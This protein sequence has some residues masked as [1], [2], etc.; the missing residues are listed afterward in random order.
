VTEETLLIGM[1][2]RPEQAVERAVQAL[3][4]AERASRELDD[5]GEAAQA[6]PAWRSLI[7]AYELAADAASTLLPNFQEVG[8]S[9]CESLGAARDALDGA[10]VEVPA[11]CFTLSAR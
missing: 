11:T 3:G 7:R 2:D 10:R 8:V 9:G 6:R 4:L 5:V 1:D